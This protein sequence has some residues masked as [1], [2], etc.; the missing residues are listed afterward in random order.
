MMRPLVLA[1]LV[2]ATGCAEN[3][4]M[5]GTD[6]DFGDSGPFAE[7]DTDAGLQAVT[8]RVD[9]LPPA[10]L[11][12]RQ[13]DP[14]LLAPHSFWVNMRDELAAQLLP[15][16]VTEGVVIGDAATPYAPLIST[17]AVTDVVSGTVRL[18]S[19]SPVMGTSSRTSEDGAF[20]ALAAPSVYTLA[21]VPDD[22]AYPLYVEPGFEAAADQVFD[23]DIGAGH[24][25]WG[26]VFGESGAPL[27][28]VEVALRSE[29]SDIQGPSTYTDSSGRYTLH[30][31]P[32]EYHVVALGRDNGRDPVI[33]TAPFTLDENGTELSVSYGSLE[34]I[35]ISGRLI[36][37]TGSGVGGSRV[38]LTAQNLSGYTGSDA[39]VTVEIPTDSA[40]NF[41]ARL[42]SGAYTVELLPPVESTVSAV[43]LGVID[44]TSAVDLGSVELPAYR[45]LT[46]IA[47]DPAGNPLAGATVR[48]AE[49]GFDKR[50]VTAITGDDGSYAMDVP[51]ADLDVLL[52]PPGD[53]SDLAA[54]RHRFALGTLESEEQLVAVEGRSIQGDLTWLDAGRD[55]AL[56]FAVVQV[57]SETGEALGQTLT[58]A[59]GHYELQVDLSGYE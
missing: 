4:L 55:E 42:V 57:F 10:D 16:V 50:F 58:D 32:G 22:P 37:S 48:A 30:A 52:T 31:A 33:A 38:R 17:P 54:T 53:R 11:T 35:G 56:S 19:D 59:S 27:V 9:V 18:L 26:Q 47:L 49:A 51:V 40:G 34:L 5:E 15:S 12:T 24:P 14:A 44:I 46:G 8:L 2:F 23:L 25:V 41:D 13:G 39:S 45:S 20:F 29:T 1:A 36:R 7:D 28:G 3:G 21:V 6:A 43:N